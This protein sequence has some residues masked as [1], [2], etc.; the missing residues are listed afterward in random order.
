MCLLYAWKVSKS[1]M[2]TA[3]D[4]LE[5]PMYV[6]V[7]VH[8]YNPRALRRCGDP[9]LEESIRE[10]GP[11]LYHKQRDCC[12][13]DVDFGDLI[14][15]WMTIFMSAR[16]QAV[17]YALRMAEALQGARIRKQHVMTS[18]SRSVKGVMGLSS[19][20]GVGKDTLI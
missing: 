1:V 3:I 6:L 10:Q 18:L 15:E 12:W 14:R 16:R 5:S 19:C 13:T 9:T 17:P 11:E 20:L 2:H 7:L 8:T 4:D